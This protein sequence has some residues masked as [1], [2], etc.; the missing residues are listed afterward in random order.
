MKRY[1]FL[2]KSYANK[3]NKSKHNLK[4][5]ANNQFLRLLIKKSLKKNSQKNEN[6]TIIFVHFSENQKRIQIGFS[7]IIQ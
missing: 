3:N 7:E 1:V 4:H 6:W 5:Y 2:I